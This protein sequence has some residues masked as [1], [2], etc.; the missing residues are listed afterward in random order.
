M[1]V[2]GHIVKGNVIDNET[3]CTH[4][5]TERDRIAIKFYCCNTYFPCHLCHEEDGCGSLQVWPRNKFHQKAILCGACGTQLT[6]DDYLRGENECPN[7]KA[8]F[9]PNC[10]LHESL[11]FEV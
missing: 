3:R 9:N 10:Q 6:I 11:Y 2:K 1:N 4:Y 8:A 5:H 7:C